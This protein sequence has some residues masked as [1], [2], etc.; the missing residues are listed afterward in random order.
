MG[1]II[2]AFILL[3]AISLLF[4]SVP[5]RLTVSVREDLIWQG[6]LV[7]FDARLLRLDRRYDFS[8]PSLNLLETAILRVYENKTHSSASEKEHRRPLRAARRWWGFINRHRTRLIPAIA[9]PRIARLEWSSIVGG[10]DAYQAAMNS[11]VAWAVKGSLLG[12]LSSCCAIGDMSVK[13][14]PNF[15]SSGYLSTLKCILKI[16]LVQIIIIKTYLAVKKSGGV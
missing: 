6:I 1:W 16:R 12:W 4:I 8:D 11:G 15:L 10:E 13:V 14:T 5:A 2:S 7:N 9:V 3:A